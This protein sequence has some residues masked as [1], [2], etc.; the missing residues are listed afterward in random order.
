MATEQEATGSYGRNRLRGLLAE[1]KLRNLERFFVE[2]HGVAVR[3]MI[4]HAG[5][6]NVNMELEDTATK[7]CEAG[8]CSGF[9]PCR[10]R[11]EL[12][13]YGPSNVILGGCGWFQAQKSQH[14]L[15][16]CI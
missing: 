15:N 16:Y 6:N 5:M 2:M 14:S 13:R 11:S 1:K 10:K 8:Y 3:W 7:R 9:D 4:F 12:I